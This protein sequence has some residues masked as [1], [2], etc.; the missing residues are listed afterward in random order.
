[1]S[2]CRFRIVV[3]LSSCMFVANKRSAS[4]MNTSAEEISDLRKRFSARD[5]LEV[6]EIYGVLNDP[7]GD[8]YDASQPL[9]WP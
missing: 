5:G 6:M 7:P 1:M 8:L 4:I 2:R 3:V 9:T